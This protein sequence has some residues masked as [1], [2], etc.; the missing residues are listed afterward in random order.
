MQLRWTDGGS[1]PQRARC[2]GC[3]SEKDLTTVCPHCGFDEEQ[4]NPAGTLPSLTS[5][6][7]GRYKTGRVLGQPDWFGVTYLGLDEK[8]QLR[9]AIREYF[10]SDRAALRSQVSPLAEGQEDV[11]MKGLQAFRDQAESL[12]RFRHAHVQRVRDCFLE[13]G[14]AYRVSDFPGGIRLS[15]YLK[16]SGERLSPDEALG[17]LSPVLEGLNEIHE[18]GF[19][20]GGFDP[21]K[22]RL[23]Q[24]GKDDSA[25]R[26]LLIGFAAERS[27]YIESGEA[28]AQPSAYDAPELAQGCPCDR[29]SEVYAASAVLYRM[30]TG[31]PPVTAQDRQQ[32]AAA[33]DPLLRP[34]HLSSDIPAHLEEALLKGLALQRQERPQSLSELLN[35]T[36]QP[37]G[38]ASS[39]APP[40]QAQP[41]AEASSEVVTYPPPP[42]PPPVRRISAGLM[43]LALVGLVA[44]LALVLSIGIPTQS[45]SQGSGQPAF[46]SAAR[47]SGAAQRLQLDQPLVA[48]VGHDSPEQVG[49][50]IEKGA[51]ADARDLSGTPVLVIAARRGRPDIVRI[52]LEAGAQVNARGSHG[53]TALRSAVLINSVEAVRLLVGKGVD[54]R[55]EALQLAKELGRPEIVQLLNESAP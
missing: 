49:A 43:A 21:A 5:L 55:A 13:R 30:L 42:A 31:E 12:S 40:L 24:R 15:H 52:L 29:L 39:H 35:L 38:D 46:R 19:V 17:I 6:Q 25:R 37:R 8:Q 32:P 51:D 11:F 33:A 34:S 53:E 26:P 54:D 16:Q 18:A 3:F 22:I 41:T 7:Q 47:G 27:A 48:A 36:R 44:V 2:P 28:S 23:I 1:P 4:D 50:L 14:L 10:P 45:S 9:V 20:H